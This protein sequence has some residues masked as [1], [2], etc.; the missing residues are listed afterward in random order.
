MA[1]ICWRG[2]APGRAACG[3]G[4]LAPSGTSRSRHKR[5][6]HQHPHRRPHAAALNAHP[7]RRR[8]FKLPRNSRLLGRLRRGILADGDADDDDGN[9]DDGAEGG[10]GSG[11]AGNDGPAEGRSSAAGA[12]GG[13]P[14]R[15]TPPRVLL[16]DPQ[17][18]TLQ[19][20]STS[21]ENVPAELRRE[22][23]L[24]AIVGRDVDVA[25]FAALI[26]LP[27]HSPVVEADIMKDCHR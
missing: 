8:A 20:G 25:S 5:T 27:L 11:A 2:P 19:V 3:P 14:G 4:Q 9:D 12:L 1:A 22:L 24:S 13:G 26:N 18:V 23:W 15:H 17:V 10:G 21:H 7:G 16:D 6:P